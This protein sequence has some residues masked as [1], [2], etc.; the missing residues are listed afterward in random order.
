MSKPEI[1]GI[2]IVK[3]RRQMLLFLGR[4]R[5]GAKMKKIQFTGISPTKSEKYQV[6]TSK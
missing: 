1:I 4:A 3:W 2:F 5:F 6:R